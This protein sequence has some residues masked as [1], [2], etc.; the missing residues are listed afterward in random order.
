[1]WSWY[2]AST[3]L[4]RTYHGANLKSQKFY[5]NISTNKFEPVPFD[6]HFWNPVLSHT[7]KKDRDRIMIEVGEDEMDTPGVVNYSAFL[8]KKLINEELFAKKYYSALKK[9]SSKKFLDNFFNKRKNR[10]SR[11]NSLIYTDYFLNDFVHFYGPGIYYFDKN[12]IYERAKI[13]REKMYSDRNK[14]FAYLK[15]GKIIIENNNIFNPFTIVNK[16]YCKKN[17]DQINIDLN[18]VL[19]KT[20]KISNIENLDKIKCYE[21]NVYNELTKQN[22]KI[23][24][25]NI[26]S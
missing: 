1:M 24:I 5:Y 2:L 18:F 22:I 19:K 6:G 26:N 3:D 9:V 16:V 23:E 14:I 20:T 21:L 11:I 15:N 12:K 17:Y 25:D 4:L 13:I 10:I 8:A 7:N